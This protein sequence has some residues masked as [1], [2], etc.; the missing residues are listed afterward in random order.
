[1]DTKNAMNRCW[2]TIWRTQMIIEMRRSLQVCLRMCA[3][4]SV[5]CSISSM[6]Y[7]AAHP[8]TVGLPLLLRPPG[9]AMRNTRGQ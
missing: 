6:Q 3:V 2:L 4:M 8:G 5:V 7:A 9:E 1:M